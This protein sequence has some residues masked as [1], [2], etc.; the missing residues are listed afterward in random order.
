MGNNSAAAEGKGLKL[1]YECRDGT[2]VAAMY[3]VLSKSEPHQ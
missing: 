1:G 2:A 3:L